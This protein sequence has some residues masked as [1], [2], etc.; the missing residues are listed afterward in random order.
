MCCNTVRKITE[1]IYIYC[2]LQ[3]KQSTLINFRT[4]NFLEK[5]ENMSNNIWRERRSIIFEFA[6]KVTPSTRIIP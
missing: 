6:G 3:M 5:L 2:A 1:F 4:T